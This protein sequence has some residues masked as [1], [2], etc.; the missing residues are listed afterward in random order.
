MAQSHVA[1]S[2][3][4]QD[5]NRSLTLRVHALVRV[6]AWALAALT[7]Y[8]QPPFFIKPI[9]KQVVVRSQKRRFIQYGLIG[10]RNKEVS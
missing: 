4:S 1:G 5:L 9:D 7:S 6:R 3:Q 10:K 8:A 2:W